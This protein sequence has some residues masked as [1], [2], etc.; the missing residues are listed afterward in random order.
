MIRAKFRCYS[1][2]DL[3]DSEQVV[4]TAVNGTEGDNA[5]WSKW[6]PMGRLEM[7]INNPGARGKFK[8]GEY[9]FLDF[10][11]TNADGK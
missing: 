7:T 5:Q 10:T 11:P 9:Y 8:V 6:T 2:T 4:L 3:G 1:V